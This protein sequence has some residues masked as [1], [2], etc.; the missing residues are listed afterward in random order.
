[1]EKI[2]I[3]RKRPYDL[4]VVIKQPSS[5]TQA[6]LP[7]DAVATFYII[8]KNTNEAVIN[9]EMVRLDIAPLDPTNDPLTALFRLELTAVETELLKTEYL[10][11]EDGKKAN[12]L[13]RGHITVDNDSATGSEIK[14]ADALIDSIYVVDLGI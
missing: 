7:V 1:M 8:D 11:A 2:I 13:Y 9:K 6:E 12:D 3:T 14:Y 10:Y 5:P 4:T